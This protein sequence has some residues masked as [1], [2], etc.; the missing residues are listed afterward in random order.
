MIISTPIASRCIIFS[1]LIL[2]GITKIN[3]KPFNLAANANPIPVLPA[4]HSIIVE[5]FLSNPFSFASSIIFNPTLS[6]IDPNGFRLSIFT[7]R[8]HGPVSMLFILT[9]GVSPIISST[10]SYFDFIFLRGG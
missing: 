7:Y 2:S 1:E 10:F 6:L 4:V 9:T 3:L 5:P 8:S